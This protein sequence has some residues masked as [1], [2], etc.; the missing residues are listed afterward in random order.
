VTLP[1]SRKLRG[2]QKTRR[3]GKAL[4]L[5]VPRASPTKGR[6]RGVAKTQY[7]FL[8][9]LPAPLF[10][11]GTKNRIFFKGYRMMFSCHH[12]ELRNRNCF[13]CVDKRGELKMVLKSERER[14]ERIFAERKETVS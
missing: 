9:M 4:S 7:L 3:G 5:P 11:L 12:D 6:L 14:E 2:T 8:E 1:L 10:Q 13:G